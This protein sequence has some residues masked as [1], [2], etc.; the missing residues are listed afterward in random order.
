MRKWHIRLE[1]CRQGVQTKNVMSIL[2]NGQNAAE[3]ERLSPGQSYPA[4][5]FS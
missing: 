3:S 2:E 1:K 5:P 4:C